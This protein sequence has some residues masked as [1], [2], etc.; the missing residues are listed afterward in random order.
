MNSPSVATSTFVETADI[1]INTS[2]DNIEKSNIGMNTDITLT[3]D[4][5]TNTEVLKNNSNINTV[6]TNTEIIPTS[7][8]HTNTPLSE[9]NSMSTI[10]DNI[11]K[12]SVAVN[13]DLDMHV[14]IET[15]TVGLDPIQQKI[16]LESLNEDINFNTQ[17]L[18]KSLSDSTLLDLED[19]MNQP[20]SLKGKA[21]LEDP[22]ELSQFE[23]VEL[24]N[25][26]YVSKTDPLYDNWAWSRPWHRWYKEKILNRNS[27][28][29]LDQNLFIKTTFG[30][31]ATNSL[32]LAVKDCLANTNSNRVRLNLQYIGWIDENLTNFENVSFDFTLKK[33]N[34][35]YFNIG[36]THYM[37]YFYN[38][39]IMITP[40]PFDTLSSV[41]TS[42]NDLSS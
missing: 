42:P 34:S 9:T 12:N 37:I 18:K 40:D 28:F 38:R 36:T 1:G 17:S 11:S 29:I 21:K 41:V 30:Y 25:I 10:T 19:A 14:Q 24:S 27:K 8:S 20:I 23:F 32:Y 6:S 2:I 5:Q 16:L 3:L 35:W 22:L 39:D 33:V 4:A 26:P 7:N 13:T 15:E 31:V